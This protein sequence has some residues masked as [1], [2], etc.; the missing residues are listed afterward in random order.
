M[1]VDTF[2]PIFIIEIDGKELPTDISS[3]VERFSYYDDEKKMDELKITI[4]D[5]DFS[6]VDNQQLQEGKEVRARWGYLGNMSEPRTCTIKE[7]NYT[8][9]EDRVARMDITALDK[10]HKLTG[11]AAR[12]CWSNKKIAEVVSDIAS[13][14]NF[15]PKIN[16]PEDIQLEFISQGGKSDWTFLKELANETGC[17][18]YVTNN[19]LHFEPDEENE[20]VRKFTWGKDGDGYLQSFRITSN[21]EKGKGT[22][23]GTESA[24]LNPLSKK[25]IKETSKAETSGSGVRV[26]ALGDKP[27]NENNK[28]G[29]SLA[30]NKVGNETAPKAKNDETGRVKATPAANANVARRSSKGKVAKAAMQSLEASA[31]VI[32][33]PYLKAKDTITIENIG[34]KFSGDWRITKVTHSISR[35]GYTCSLNLAKSNTNSS[36][37]KKPE[38]APKTAKNNNNAKPANNNASNKKPPTRTVNLSETGWK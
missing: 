38:G 27:V 28:G 26:I 17:V 15:T 33:L 21:A 14:H 12:T 1:S 32:G 36:K 35:S 7:I 34:Q 29:G 24:G 16:I 6:F 13:K 19:E 37:D 4:C 23:R 11:R 31:N 22:S 8:F 9:G 30:E 2:A 3:H 10:G 20:P 25:K 18:F 5:L